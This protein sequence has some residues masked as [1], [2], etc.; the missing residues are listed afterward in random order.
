VA[1][2]AR[3]AWVKKSLSAGERVGIDPWLHSKADLE[4]WRTLLAQRGVG[5]EIL[6][7]NPI[8]RIW[9][10]GRAPEHR[11][12]IVDYPVQYAGEDYRSKCKSLAAY[13]NAAGLRALLVADPEDASWLLNVRA[14]D[15][16]LKAEVGDWH[17]VP[18]C[19]S[20]AL[21]LSEGRVVWFV[22]KERLAPE[23]AMRDT[24][25]VAIAAPASLATMLRELARQ[26]TIGADVR[27]TPA[28][29]TSIVEAEGNISAD[30]TVACRRWRKHPAE[31]E[32]ARRAHIL[33]AAAVVRFMA[34][35]ARTIPV[36][37]VS[38]LDAARALA[39]FRMANPA[40]KGPSMPLMS[41]SGRSGAQPHYVPRPSSNV[42]L[43]DHPIYWMDSGGQYLGGTTDNTLTLAV[44]VP[45]RKHVLAH[46][47]VLKGFIAFATARVPSGTYG[48]RLDTIARQ[49]L[50]QEGMDFAHATGHGV[51]NYLN[52]HEGP[53][54]S[55]EPGP[56]TWV[57]VESGMIITN[58]PGYYAPGDFGLRIESHM[59]TVPSHHANFVEFET[60][61]RLPIDP[62]LV[63][64]DRLTG[65]ERRWLAD[66]HRTVLQ[67]LEP[68]LDPPSAE[69][70][71]RVVEAF[72]QTDELPA[73]T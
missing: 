66:Y 42:L 20:R 1:P 54:I 23:V 71:H 9:K 63:D 56:L 72:V 19:T 10:E 13:V 61:S 46:T 28:A 52:I 25:S 55:R 51:G 68:L 48:F 70:L 30:E 3:S 49:A 57:P 11:P 21:V 2:T 32:A 67:D 8:D 73:H 60:I 26:G 17:V 58:E 35:L 40:Y 5:L 12:T 33:D 62:C 41:A 18:S 16:S 29:L 22:D 4:Q 43:N 31:L 27:R 64:F 14:A 45:E 38:E 7:T 34:W 37:G 44:G 6:P 15:D 53:A 50:W 39:E 47:L 69:W 59:I 65:T 24:E 36:R